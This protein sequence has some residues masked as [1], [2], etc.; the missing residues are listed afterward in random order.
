MG[1]GVISA[2][3]VHYKQHV[4][5]ELQQN[6]ELRG[7]GGQMPFGRFPKIHPFWQRQASIRNGS[8]V[9]SESVMTKGL[10]LEGLMQHTTVRK[11]IHWVSA[12]QER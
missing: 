5:K 1:G 12:I 7:G 11:V 4:K 3:V 2:N 8:I 6:F 9:M 10:M